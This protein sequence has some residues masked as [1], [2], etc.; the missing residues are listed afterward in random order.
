MGGRN[1]W[2][3]RIL[4]GRCVDGRHRAVNAGDI[5][6][7]SLPHVAPEQRREPEQFFLT[8]QMLFIAGLT[9]PDC[10][11]LAGHGLYGQYFSANGAVNC[12]SP[13]SCCSVCQ[14]PGFFAA[15][16]RDRRLSYGCALALSIGMIWLCHAAGMCRPPTTD[17][18]FSGLAYGGSA[19]GFRHRPDESALPAAG[20][21]GNEAL[22]PLSAQFGMDP[23]GGGII[24]TDQSPVSLQRPALRGSRDWPY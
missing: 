9:R 1:L 4:A 13:A 3:V 10:P 18:L 11:Y 23:A 16:D 12:S 8:I 14:S 5:P 7:H 22:Y 6:S 17:C 15:E 2:C 24:G 19:A 21:A 20:M